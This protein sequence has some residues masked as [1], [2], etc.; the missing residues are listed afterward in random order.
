MNIVPIKKQIKK[1][2]LQW[3][4]CIL[5]G[6]YARRDKTSP[7]RAPNNWPPAKHNPTLTD[8]P[9]FYF[10]LIIIKSVIIMIMNLPTGK[11]SSTASSSII[12]IPGIKKS[13]MKNVWQSSKA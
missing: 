6:G 5:E 8:S 12:G 13:P 7:I 10:F 4:V 3:R 11:V 9:I 1:A 2:M